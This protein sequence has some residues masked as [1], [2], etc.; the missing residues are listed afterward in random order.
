MRT[1][2]TSVRP[3]QPTP[4]IASSDPTRLAEERRRDFVRLCRLIFRQSKAPMS[5]R[6]IVSQALAH[7]APGYYVDYTYA[8]RVTGHVMT[9]PR[10]TA[11]RY[12]RGKWLEIADRCRRELD[13]GRATSLSHALALVLSDGHASGFFLSPSTALRILQRANKALEQSRTSHSKPLNP[14]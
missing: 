10:A 8:L 7:E 3:A 9:M 5:Q 14:Q 11:L 13:A 4:L 12:G 2:F 6:E 1:T